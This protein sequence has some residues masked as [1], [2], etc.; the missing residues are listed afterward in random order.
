[1]SNV[2]KDA[3]RM[4][5]IRL[6]LALGIIFLVSSPVRAAMRN[7]TL[8]SSKLEPFGNIVGY[9]LS[10]AIVVANTDQ[11][12]VPQAVAACR[13]RVVNDAIDKEMDSP[14]K[15]GEQYTKLW[16]EILGASHQ[17]DYLSPTGKVQVAMCLAEMGDWGDS[18]SIVDEL[19]SNPRT[20][21]ATLFYVQAFLNLR[22]NH[23]ADSLIS[24]EKAFTAKPEDQK[25]IAFFKEHFPK[26]YESERSTLISRNTSNIYWSGLSDDQRRTIR[27]NGGAQLDNENARPCHVSY[28]SNA[29]AGRIEI[30]YYNCISAGTIGKE[31]YTF[32]NGILKDHTMI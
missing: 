5:A 1:M 24:I 21:N 2:W 16:R 19:L 10:Y 27:D 8:S 4:T 32:V 30:W 12:L 23:E 11:V 9:G 6:M 18:K 22:L 31:S 7:E 15:P 28:S 3:F 25:I 17:F 29:Y 14:V 13:A 20:T 26:A